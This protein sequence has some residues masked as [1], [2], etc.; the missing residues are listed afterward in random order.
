MPCQ[1]SSA[2]GA[3]NPPE[4]ARKI[5]HS[6][7]FGNASATIREAQKPLAMFTRSR[8]IMGAFANSRLTDALAI[9]GAAI[10]LTPGVAPLIQTFGAEAPGLPS[11]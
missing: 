5:A 6:A 11:R 2:F 7:S 1:F 3:A 4:G 9:L 10:L 8:D